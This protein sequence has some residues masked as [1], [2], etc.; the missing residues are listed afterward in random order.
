[1]Q[2][3]FLDLGFKIKNKSQE[4]AVWKIHFEC[5]IQFKCSG[6]IP[7]KMRIGVSDKAMMIGT[8]H[9]VSTI[10]LKELNL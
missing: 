4:N 8:V 6:A 2:S 3:I 5:A 10:Y 9:K 1:M 7:M